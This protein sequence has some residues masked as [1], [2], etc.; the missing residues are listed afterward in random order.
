MLYKTSKKMRGMDMRTKAR[1]RFVV[2]DESGKPLTLRKLK[3]DLQ[4][5]KDD[6]ETYTS[7]TDQ[8]EDR[9]HAFF[10]VKKHR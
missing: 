8:F 9:F 5:I 1:I 4:E 6:L 7:S 2:K 10:N 3:K